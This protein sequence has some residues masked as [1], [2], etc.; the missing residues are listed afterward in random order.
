MSTSPAPPGAFQRQPWAAPP[1]CSPPQLPPCPAAACSQPLPCQGWMLPSETQGRRKLVAV[2]VTGAWLVARVP[3]HQA[4]GERWEPAA[5]A[6]SLRP[7]EQG[8]HVLLPA[9]V[10]CW[11]RALLAAPWWCF[12]V[13]WDRGR[14]GRPRHQLERSK[15]SPKHLGGMED[16]FPEL[17]LVL[18]C[19]GAMLW[20]QELLCVLPCCLGRGS[21]PP[22]SWAWPKAAA[23]GRDPAEAALYCKK[24]RKPLQMYFCAA[25]LCSPL[26]PS[27]VQLGNT[28]AV[29][30]RG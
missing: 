27:P 29:S 9:R 30:F 14:G 21:L 6:S 4:T 17:C 3:W 10:C 5:S 19:L 8:Q 18:G 12:G 2:G 24:N 26:S 7:R 23:P 1:A 20:S 25:F 11:S 13:G 28:A 15:M 16:P 22:P